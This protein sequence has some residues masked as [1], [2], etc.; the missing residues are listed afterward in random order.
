MTYDQKLDGIAKKVPT[1]AKYVELN[2][3]VAN[4]T[5]PNV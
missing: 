1:H 5:L 2:K 4:I 3:M